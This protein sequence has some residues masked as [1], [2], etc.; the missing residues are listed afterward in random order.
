MAE[1]G[2][3]RG[4][5]FRWLRL[6]HGWLSAACFLLLLF[7]SAT[8]IL[9]NHPGWLD[10]Q[11]PAQRETRVV[12]SP[13]DV[14]MVRRAAEPARKLVDVVS[15]RAE[16]EGA[17]VDGDVAGEDVFVRLQGVRGTSDV[18]GDLRTGAVTVVVERDHPAAILNALHRAEHAGPVWRLIVDA[19]GVALIVMSLTGYL[20]FLSLRFRLR[21]ALAIT[22]ASL[23]GLA[24][25]YA[26]AVT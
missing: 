9:L 25:V 12:L 18:R 2:P 26:F 23:A 5:V 6:V 1:A 21:T 16:L 4:E 17:F 24:A 7:F 3:S 14:A 8:G 22:L 10:A 13:A 20:I 11:A 15:G 19:A